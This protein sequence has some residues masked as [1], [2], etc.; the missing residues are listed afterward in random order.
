MNAVSPELKKMILELQNLSA[1]SNFVL[2]G[3]TSLALRYHHR[4]SID[5]DF[6]SVDSIGKKGFERIII[7][8]QKYFGTAV[9]KSNS[10]Q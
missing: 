3:G 6:I 10:D 1:L 5:I 8:V 9:L 2:G 4:I 7:E